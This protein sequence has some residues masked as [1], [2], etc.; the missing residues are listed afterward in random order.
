VRTKTLRPEGSSSSDHSV[1]NTTNNHTSMKNTTKHLRTL[2]AAVALAASFT[3]GAQAAIDTQYN[4]NDL[5]LYGLQKNSAGTDWAGNVVTFSLGSTFNVFR[6]AAT[7]GDPTYG[8]VINLGNINTILTSNYGT[9]WTGLVADKLYFGATG[10]NGSVNAASE[11]VSNGDYAR[12]AYITSPRLGAG[13]YGQS[14]S[15]QRNINTDNASGTASAI[16]GNSTGTLNLST[17]VALALGDTLIDTQ[18]SLTPGGSPATAYGS[19][20]GGVIGAASAS[21]YNFDTINNVVL[22]L[23]LYRITPSLAGGSSAWQNANGIAADYGTGNPSEPGLGFYL[24]TITLSSNGDVNFV[25]TGATPIPEPGTIA[26]AVLLAG[27]AWLRSRKRA[28]L[29]S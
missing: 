27:G 25:G 9:N 19:I 28:Q 14:N 6:Q 29:A 11:T 10:Q 20:S 8:T 2:G 24:G 4:H 18:N 7:P 12:T 5:L 3:P 16:R 17:P 21:T 13:T 22:G 15:N 1:T 23:D 26:A